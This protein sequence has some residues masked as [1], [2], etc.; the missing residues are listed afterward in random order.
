[1]PITHEDINKLAALAKIDLDIH[2][3]SINFKDKLIANLNNI[4]NLVGQLQNINTTNIS[5]IAHSHEL[6]TQ[7]LRPDVV[8]ETNVRENMQA[9]AP[10][11]SIEAGLY[12]VPK[13]IE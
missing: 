9:I 5:P 6:A 8:T 4:I 12:L 11:N 3:N 1:M 10:S 2:P 13:V 7:R